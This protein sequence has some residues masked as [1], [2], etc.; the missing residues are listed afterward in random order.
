MVGINRVLKLNHG[1]LD[2]ERIEDDTRASR[3]RFTR[4]WAITAHFH[5]ALPFSASFAIILNRI[6][7]IHDHVAQKGAQISFEEDRILVEP[8]SGAY[9]PFYSCHAPFLAISL[10][11]TLPSPINH[12]NFTTFFASTSP[13]RRGEGEMMRKRET[14]E[15]LKI[16]E[17]EKERG[18]FF[19][20]WIS[21]WGVKL[22][23]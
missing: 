5:G 13:M 22:H 15:W 20:F 16:E 7:R 11:H 17:R 10:D 12:D 6:S 23:L 9:F 14:L 18:F 19:N 3:S 4:I 21:N 8:P 1:E 2:A